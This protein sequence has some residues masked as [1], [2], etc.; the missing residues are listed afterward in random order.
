MWGGFNPNSHLQRIYIAL[1]SYSSD[2]DQ[3]APKGASDKGITTI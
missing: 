2:P 3:R 1:F